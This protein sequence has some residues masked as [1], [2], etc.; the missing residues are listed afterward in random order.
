M[1]IHHCIHFDESNYPILCEENDDFECINKE[2]LSSEEI[3]KQICELSTELEK[4]QEQLKY[5]S[6]ITSFI[7]DRKRWLEYTLDHIEKK[8][9]I[10]MIFIINGDDCEEYADPN[11]YLDEV[12]D[13]ALKKTHNTGRPFRE[14]QIRDARGYML[15]PDMKIRSLCFDKNDNSN[16]QDRLF[17]SLK[18]GYG[19]SSFSFSRAE[20]EIM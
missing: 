12:R 9:K 20:L 16:S 6:D 5:F 19:A 7:E 4:A 8:D 18:I 17:L 3:K 13:R 15:P 2:R 14:W 1:R 11:E 10:A